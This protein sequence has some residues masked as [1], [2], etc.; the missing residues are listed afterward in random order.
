VLCAC[1]TSTVVRQSSTDIDAH[2]SRH[3]QAQ[4]K[5]HLVILK[6]IV[7]KHHPQSLAFAVVLEFFGK[8]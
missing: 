8:T 4:R 2:L 7:D 1:Q 5:G 6:N 3:G